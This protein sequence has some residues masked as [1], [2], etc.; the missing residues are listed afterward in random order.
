[1]NFNPYAAPGAASDAIPGD[2][3]DVYIETLPSPV[4]RAAG[5]AALLTGIAMLFCCVRFVV[6][7]ASGPVALVIE[8]TLVFLAL[9]EFG[10]GWGVTGAR[11]GWIYAGF[12]AVPF[13]GI[14]SLFVLATGA[15]AG[16]AGMSLAIVDLVLLCLG[17][18]K[19][20]RMGRARVQ[21]KRMNQQ[22]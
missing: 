15:F 7:G 16:M 4:V 19:V 13:V 14:A 22:A 10:V 1:M 2:T 12:A 21:M 9:L 18:S 3:T 11:S 6:A 8:G 17:F 5:G 20:R